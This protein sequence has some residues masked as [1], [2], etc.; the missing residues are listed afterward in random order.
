MENFEPVAAI[1]KNI[2]RPKTTSV[3]QEST[4]WEFMKQYEINN[5]VIQSHSTLGLTYMFFVPV[6]KEHELLTTFADCVFNKKE[7][8]VIDQCIS[9]PFFHFFIDAD[10]SGTE[11]I[12]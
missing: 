12:R 8:I 2:Q 10:I 7:K 5:K 3:I 1:L 6:Q 4:F 11:P 9:S